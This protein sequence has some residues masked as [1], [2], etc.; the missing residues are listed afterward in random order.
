MTVKH[1]PNMQAPDPNPV[2]ALSRQRFDVV[3]IGGTPAGIVFAL[4]AA[5][6]GAEVLLV[7]HTRHLGGMAANGLGVWDTRYE[8]RR[9]PIHDEIRQAFFSYYQARYGE[10]SRQYRDALPGEAGH[11]NGKY[12][13]HVA[14]FILTGLVRQEPRITVLLEHYPV[15]ADRVGNLIRGITFSRMDGGAM[16]RVQAPL[17]ADCSYEADTFPLAGVRYRVGR[18]SRDEH[19]EAH[20]GV[21]YM[22]PADVPPDEQTAR[23]AALHHGLKL[24]HFRGYQRMHPASTG[25]GD[26]NVQAINYRVILT[27]DPARRLPIPKPEDYDPEAFRRLEFRAEIEGIPNGK[28]GLNRP[29]LLGIH[30]TYVEGSWETRRLIMDRHWRMALAMIWH[31]QHAP[32]WSAEERLRWLEYGLAKDEFT[33]NGHRPY[34]IYCREGRRLLGRFLLTQADTTPAPGLTRPPLHVD[35]IAFTEWYIDSHACTPRQVG[36]SLEEGKVMLYHETFPGHI[37]YRA[38]LPQGLDNMI[39]PVNLSATHV[40]WNAVRLEATW[41]HVAESAAFAA[42]LAL[43]H[44]QTFAAIDRTEL[45]RTLAWRGV[46]LTFF[47]DI[48]SAPE[49]DAVAATQFFSALGFFPDYDARLDEP[50]DHATA[51]IWTSAALAGEAADPMAVAGKLASLSEAPPSLVTAQQFAAMLPADATVPPGEEPVSRRTALACLWK[52]VAK[53][54][55]VMKG[56]VG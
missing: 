54:T 13:P 10:K 50:L 5:R 22:E 20:A 15:E 31:R 47:N 46:A 21:I 48:E 23:L 32:S 24:R 45:R 29:Q 18:E 44:K 11:S 19:G 9:S 43:R 55:A 51:E 36:G 49:N 17:F 52:L 38:L 42:V 27:K 41:M 33:D 34:E 7:N 3:V 14:E 4:R 53:D 40:A 56:T 12:E 37:P 30:N 16:V 6:E 26:R 39:V 25:E 28:I 1:H 35:S 2:E 8:R